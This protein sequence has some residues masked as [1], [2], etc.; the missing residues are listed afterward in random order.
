[1]GDSIRFARR[2]PRFSASSLLNKPEKPSAANPDNLK[3]FYDKDYWVLK[4]NNRDE[5]H[6]FWQRH[7]PSTVAL[8]RSSGYS[9]MSSWD[10]LSQKSGAFS[11]LEQ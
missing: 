6:S 5:E 4:N 2:P 10:G 7:R 9:P 8:M 1:M 3:R 11:R